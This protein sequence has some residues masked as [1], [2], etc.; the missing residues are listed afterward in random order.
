[1][2]TLTL[3]IRRKLVLVV[4][5]FL[6]M[7]TLI[8]GL[9]Y[10]GLN[11]LS[12]VRA[13]IGAESLWSKSEKNALTALQRYVLKEEARDLEIFFEELELPAATSRARLEVLKKDP[14]FKLLDQALIEAKNDPSEVHAMGLLMKRAQGVKYI[15]QALAAWALG[16]QELFNLKIIALQI[17]NQIQLKKLSPVQKTQFLQ[18]ILQAE[19]RLTRAELTFSNTLTEGALW[20]KK[21]FIGTLISIALLFL[22]LGFSISY[23]I[24]K[25]ILQQIEHLRLA[26][27]LVEKGDLGK[28]VPVISSDELGQLASVFNQMTATLSQVT[29]ERNQAQQAFEARAHQLSEAQATAH[30]GSWDFDL[31]T[32]Q[33]FWSDELFRILGQD[34]KIFI[35]T[36]EK[37]ISFLSVEDRSAL[38]D[39]AK[40]AIE[41]RLPFTKVIKIQRTGDGFR[42]LHIQA[43]V[44][45]SPDGTPIRIL[46]TAQDITERQQLQEQLVQASKMASLGEMAGGVAHEINTPLG[47]IT[48]LT[49]HARRLLA[50]NKLEMHSLPPMLEKLEMMAL[51]IA[52][53]V[54]GLRSFSREGAGDVFED[55]SVESIIEDTLSLCEERFKSQKIQFSRNQVSSDLTMSVRSVQ[56]A[57]V[58][59]NLFNNASDA[60]T[61]KP[62][63]WIRLDVFE[64]NE[65]VEIRITDSGSGI[66]LAIQEKMFQPFFTTKEIGLGTGLGLS[67]S[68]GII[69]AHGGDLTIDNHSPNTCFKIRLPKWQS[70][71][72][73]QAS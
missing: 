27:A 45:R 34:P 9:S 46:G 66:P 40:K 60:V 19:Q 72:L 53:I 47:V 3:S 11:C 29:R 48:L 68:M 55:I 21:V 20:L 32:Q 41:N 65:F 14:D 62:N 43:R 24:S 56:I 16:D 57:Q 36:F 31:T 59:L 52:K 37:V 18:Q 17:E 38:G 54:K 25:N 69:K 23:T 35:P 4:W 58:L 39:E 71:P 73:E 10:L 44:V 70:L 7:I 15:D 51:R 2:E 5:T 61:G 42:F 1:M 50:E 63:P 33:L 8:T 6:I 64:K 28:I 30:L 22:A 67:I 49:S 12:I 26:A 13:Y